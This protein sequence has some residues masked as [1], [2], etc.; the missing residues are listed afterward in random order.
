MNGHCVRRYI[1]RT[2]KYRLLSDVERDVLVSAG[3]RCADWSRVMVAEGFDP[4]RVAGCEFYGDV[5]IGSTGGS[6]LL[7]GGMR[8]DC[9]LYH[10]VLSDV[11]VGD[12]CLV[13]NV[14]GYISNMDIG[15]GCVVSGCS[16][17]YCGKDAVFGCGTEVSVLDETGG[18]SVR[19]FPGMSS[20]FAWL[21]V[22]R[23]DPD[24]LGAVSS[25]VDREVAQVRS[26]RGRIADGVVMTGCGV[27]SDVC[28]GEGSR[29]SGVSLLRNVTVGRGCVVGEGVIAEDCII[30]DGS[31][32]DGAAKLSCMFVGESVVIG[33]H[34]SGQHSLV[35]SNSH[36]ENGEICAAFAGPHTVAHHKSILLIGGMYSFFN[37]GS[38]A[39]HSNHLYSLGPCHF[40]VLERG[41]KMASDAYVMMPAYV[42]AYT[43]IL[44][45]HRRHSDSSMFPFSYLIEKKGY[46]YCMP[47]AVLSGIGLFRDISKWPRRDRRPGGAGRDKVIY[48]LFTPDVCNSMA[49]AMY[50]L[51]RVLDGEQDIDGVRVD[52]LD[53][54]DY[55]ID[56]LYFT[57]DSVRKGIRLYRLALNLA[58]G[59]ALLAAMKEDV[60]ADEDWDFDEWHDLCGLLAPSDAVE[61][62]C[63]GV[64]DGSLS[65]IGAV[66]DVFE[67]LFKAYPVYKN[68]WFKG[69]MFAGELDADAVLKARAEAVQEMNRMLEDSAVRDQR[70]AHMF[71]GDEFTPDRS[72]YGHLLLK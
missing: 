72:A 37:A 44:G 59:D 70:L 46:S 28:V 25:L 57:P 10:A 16:S 38:G 52:V 27:L 61:E 5:R 53:K 3:N 60:I 14:S 47:G 36:F 33:S 13:R 1:F 22:F 39:N 49:S 17:V 48:D 21:Y 65:S 41:C 24:F 15:D 45:R 68:A 56:G 9:G 58:Y 12:G 51:E 69:Q 62:L 11:T 67:G 2:M 64:A 50:L 23:R 29:L 54:G 32:V 20:Q 26:S 35:F 19:I 55:V 34:F 63:A 31:R 40:G 4:R 30:G 42:G 6:C 18:R 43:L 8:M 66:E 7:D 71:D